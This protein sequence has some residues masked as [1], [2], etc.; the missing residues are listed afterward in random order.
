MKINLTVWKKYKNKE[1]HKWWIYYKGKS[2]LKI[3]GFNK[4]SS[5]L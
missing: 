3:F 2:T 5:G 1:I 4:P